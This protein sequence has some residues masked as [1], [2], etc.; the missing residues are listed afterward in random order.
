[1]HALMLIALIIIPFVFAVC[2]Y[3]VLSMMV[4]TVFPSRLAAFIDLNLIHLIALALLVP[5]THVLLKKRTTYLVCDGL[6]LDKARLV[7][8]FMSTLGILAL[9][10]FIF[11]EAK[12]VHA[13]LPERLPLYAAVLV[14]T[15]LQCLLEELFTR[16]IIAR[17]VMSQAFICSKRTLAVTS[18]ACAAL[19]TLLHW[20][21]PE[22]DMYPALPLA[23]YYFLFA[24]LST[25]VCVRDRGFEL[26]W[27]AHSANNIFVAL[28]MGYPGCV[29]DTLPLFMQ[30]TPPG[31]ALLYAQLA[32]IFLTLW[33]LH[34]RMPDRT[35][36]TTASAEQWQG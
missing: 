36:R 29:Y 35:G 30:E 27:A 3:P 20:A 19:F 10:S 31:I 32:A 7:A 15:P 11:A 4:T 16:S 2:A 34:L 9:T 14:I 22:W 28:F 21:S 13:P 5:M 17:M 25:L 26:S 23:A 18:L 8:G 1:M 12:A 24:L 33:L 6:G